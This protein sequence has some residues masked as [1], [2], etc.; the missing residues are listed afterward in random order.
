MGTKSFCWEPQVPERFRIDYMGQR[1]D[2]VA[3]DG[4]F[5]AYTLPGENV[6]AEPDPGHADRRTLVSV[7]TPSPDRIAPICRHFGVCG[8]CATQHWAGDPYRTWK[9]DIVA[10]AL[11]HA[12]IETAVDPIVDAHGAGRR[13]AVFHARRGPSDLDVGFAAP[14]AH[15]I[16][17]IEECPVLVPELGDAIGIARALA[18]A[19]EPLAKPLD[20][21]FTASDSGLDV[22]IR[23]SGPLPPPR[24]AALAR[25]A[26]EL[27]LA[28]LTRHG[29]LVAQ[30]VQ[31][32][33]R[34]GKAQVP[35]PPGSFLQATRAGEET[36]AQLVLEH[37]SAAK[38]V[39]D[40]FCGVGPFAL[41]LAER[42]SVTALDSD[43][44]AIEALVKAARTPGLKPIAAAKRDLFRTP[45]TVQE[46]AAFDTVVFDPPRQG[47]EA[48]TRVLAASKVKRVIAVS[49]NAA[50]FARDARTL[51]DGG[52]RLKRVTPVDQF[53]YSAHVELV[54]LFTR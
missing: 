40:L 50:T 27:R 42:A 49:C 3:A 14:R 45:L 1:G 43:Q 47:A 39:A 30:G 25:L 6:L 16:V 18:T 37:A 12:G 9:R 20:L 11:A 32:I 26:S 31:P 15:W 46:L 2:G 52:Y 44:G 24:A 4:A 33:L 51:I 28:R 35:L 54:A 23:G 22:D 36:L 7:E 34:M 17:P 41:R 8:G 19:L 48:Q 5:I 10:S 38:R 13:R 29:E 53:R 21:H